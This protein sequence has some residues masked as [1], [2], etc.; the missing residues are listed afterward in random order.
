MCTIT[1]EDTYFNVINLLSIVRE[2]V[3]GS[4]L[5]HK[6]YGLESHLSFCSEMNLG[7]GFRAFF[8]NRLV[9]GVVFF[10]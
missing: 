4:C 3:I 9:K 2:G 5:R 6:K 10:I 1:N 7:H 8:G